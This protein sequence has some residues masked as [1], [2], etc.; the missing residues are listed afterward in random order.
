MA[1]SLNPRNRFPMAD[2]SIKI[3]GAR[4]NNLK[5]LDLE[6][7]LGELIV[8]TGVSGSGKSSLAFDTVYAEGQRRYVETFSPYAR[9]FLD[10]MDRPQVERIDGIPPSIAI[11]QTNPVRT[12]RS[13]VGTMTEL[14]DHLKLLFARAAKLY[15]HGCGREVLR[16][17][18]DGIYEQL[19]HEAGKEAPRLIV[20][21]AITVPHNFTADE[22]RKVLEQQ[23]YTKIHSE[24]DNIIEV[25]QDRMR[26][27]EEN[28]GRLVEALE[29][30][31]DKGHGKVVVYPLD[32]NREP[33]T[34]FK[35]SS[36]LHCAH[37]DIH[38][39]DP[40]PNL[41]SFNSALGAC[42]TCRGFGRT[43]GIDWNLVIPDDSL[44][45]RDG[46]IKP[47][48]SGYSMECQEDLVR[49]G[50]KRK[51]DLDTPWKDLDEE[52]K[53]WVIDGEGKWDGKTWYGV[54]EYF[55]FLESKAYKMHIRV[56]L[57]K[58]R[59]YDVCPTC[60]G[61]RLKD[62]ALD[63]R[64]GTKEEAD[65][66]LDPALRHRHDSITMPD[67]VFRNLPGLNL[68]DV[69]QLPLERARY[70]FDKLFGN[71]GSDM[72]IS[73]QGEGLGRGE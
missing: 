12:S 67:A 54:Q 62:E 26:L 39:K 73:H 57:S 60:H 41:F 11:D 36:G 55:D 52:T 16:D 40:Q 64:V 35:F 66:V 59:S 2:D 20:T 34:P 24:H 4:Q 68:F 1:S 27:S 30:A 9:Q 13:T 53:R 58:Y 63:F 61:A 72:P 31:L 5:N 71:S 49:Y 43:I 45:L 44:S 7:P 3:H 38:Y 8:V 33:G 28:R 17:T 18:P 69:M 37:C 22:I 46:A 21:F 23:G 19:M 51:I 47:F 56:M 70:F 29:I 25:V 65:A 42:D 32:E 50:R 15:C 48:R 10:R 6:L 14:N